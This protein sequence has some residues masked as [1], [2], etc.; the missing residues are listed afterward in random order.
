MMM[1]IIIIIIIISQTH[2][3]RISMYTT[4][5][6]DFSTTSAIKLYLK[7][8]VSGLKGTAQCADGRMSSRHCRDIGTRRFFALSLSRRAT[9]HSPRLSRSGLENDELRWSSSLLLFHSVEGTWRSGQGCPPTFLWLRVAA[10]GKRLTV[11]TV[12]KLVP[13][14]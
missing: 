10:D 14:L 7:R 1:L 8:G 12:W 6:V 3:P 11:L 13:R 5:G 4:A 9:P 2:L